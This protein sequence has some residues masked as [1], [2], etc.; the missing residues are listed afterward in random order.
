M[1]ARP[2]CRLDKTHNARRRDALAQKLSSLPPPRHSPGFVFSAHTQHDHPVE[3]PP[4]ATIISNGNIFR[5]IKPPL[6]PRVR[7][8]SA[9]SHP[10]RH[11]HT[12]LP[13]LLHFPLCP[14]RFLVSSKARP[15]RTCKL[16]AFVATDS[17]G[18]RSQL[19]PPIAPVRLSKPPSSPLSPHPSRFNGAPTRRA[20]NF[21]T[22]HKG[23]KGE[24]VSFN[25]RLS[26]RP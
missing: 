25:A 13:S 15:R 20:L 23:P 4:A 22:E 19:Q 17:T 7:G 11:T 14:A 1:F 5:G 6:T 3:R 26:E 9:R 12:H 10:L 18:E 21:V 2:T 16:A 24:S 8:C